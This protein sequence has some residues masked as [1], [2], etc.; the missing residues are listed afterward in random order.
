MV[1]AISFISFVFPYTATYDIMMSG[2]R[3]YCTI[4]NVIITIIYSTVF[5]R[6]VQ[7]GQE[8]VGKRRTHTEH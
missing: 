4:S 1:L 7:T 2:L 8:G 5:S 6:H 3:E